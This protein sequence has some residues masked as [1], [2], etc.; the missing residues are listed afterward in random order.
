MKLAEALISRADLNKRIAQLSVRLNNN[1]TVQEGEKPNE[2][3]SELLA[4]LDDCITQLE[5]LI[6]RINLTNSSVKLN[7]LTLTELLAKRDCLSMKLGTYRDF[8]RTASQLSYRGLRSEIKWLSAV[9]VRQL[10]R[11]VDKL[12]AEF[13]RLDSDM[14]A[15]NWTTELI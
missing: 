12:S 1:A 13:R 9:D 3:P 11:Y 5:T 7:G 6:A 10:Q 2:N 4:E 14:Q 8:L 15:L